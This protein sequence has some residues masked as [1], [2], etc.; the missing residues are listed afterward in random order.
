MLLL[1]TVARVEAIALG[2]TAPDVAIQPH[3]QTSPVFV[4]VRD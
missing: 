4:W 3:T 2:G 1:L